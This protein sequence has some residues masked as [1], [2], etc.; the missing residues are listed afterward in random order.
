MSNSKSAGSWRGNIMIPSLDLV[1]KYGEI[2]PVARD[3]QDSAGLRSRI[4]PS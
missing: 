4:A 3:G 2:I 1:W